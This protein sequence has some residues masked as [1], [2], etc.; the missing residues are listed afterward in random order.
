MKAK[1]ANVHAKGPKKVSTWDEVIL[2]DE[3]ESSLKLQREVVTLAKK[4]CTHYGYENC[5]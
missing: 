4:A 1:K 5:E 3:V 2:A